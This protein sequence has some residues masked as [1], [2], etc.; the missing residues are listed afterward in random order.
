MVSFPV[1][2]G[3]TMP[4][5][6]S[7]GNRAL[8]FGMG[9]NAGVHYEINKVASIGLA[10]HS[11]VWVEDFTWNRKDL[12]GASHILKFKMNLPKLISM[13]AG[14]S[15]SKGTRIG[16]DAR[17]IDYANTTGFNKV[18][19]NADGSVSGFGWQNIWAVGGGVQQHIASFTKLIL[20]YNYSGNPVPAKYTRA[21]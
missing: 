19:Y 8:A 15:P 16:V 12:S 17:W 9:F 21:R 20:G 14:I 4:Y 2:A 3:S 10:Y 13:G 1:T 6:R 18:G 11:P 5:Y 7:T